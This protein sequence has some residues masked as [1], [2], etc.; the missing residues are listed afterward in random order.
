MSRTIQAGKR[1][2]RKWIKWVE[3][4]V[5]DHNVELISV[6]HED[7][8]K[9]KRKKVLLLLKVSDKHWREHKNKSIPMNK[10]IYLKVGID[11]KDVQNEIKGYGGIWDYKKGGWKIKHQ[12]LYLNNYDLINRM[13]DPDENDR[14]STY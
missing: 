7:D 13:F 12:D 9:Q 14:D 11:E 5:L 8:K 4:N 2:T 10:Y 3:E 6:R 1:G